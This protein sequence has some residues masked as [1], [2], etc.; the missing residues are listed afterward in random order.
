MIKSKHI[1]FLIYA[2][3]APREYKHDQDMYYDDT[4]YRNL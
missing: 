4:S 2:I 1:I 3:N